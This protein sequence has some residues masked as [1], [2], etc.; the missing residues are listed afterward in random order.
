MHISC[1]LS[2]RRAMRHIMTTRTAHRS[3]GRITRMPP[4]LRII[5]ASNGNRSEGTPTARGTFTF[6]LTVRD[7]DGQ[8]A[9]QVTRIT[10]N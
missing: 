6:N 8:Q 4:G 3:E 1:R 2:F 7:Q 10:I 5:R 9:T